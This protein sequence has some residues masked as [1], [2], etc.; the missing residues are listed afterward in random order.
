MFKMFYPHE[1]VK[2]VFVIDYDKLYS[3][4]YRGILFDLDNTLAHHGED[5]TKEI[6]ELFRVIQRTGLKT[7]IVSNNSE[8]RIKRF[9]KNIDSLYVHEANKPDVAGFLKAVELLNIKKEE[10]VVVGDRIF[11]DIY[12]AN[13]SGIDNIL[14][15]YMRHS[16]ET[17]IG[18]KRNL[19]KIV[20]Q[21]YSFNKRF[22]NR[23]GDIC[24]KEAAN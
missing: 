17:K 3:M 12:G 16:N 19:E 11:D 21:F 22:Q 5:S 1:Y 6:D 18:I 2:N 8:E 14:V 20:L 15:E 24:N 23:L 7:I 10:A 13:K 4:G 9:L